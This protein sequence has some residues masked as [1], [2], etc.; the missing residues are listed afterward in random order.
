VTTAAATAAPG[1]RRAAAA[2]ALLSLAAAVV[3]LVLASLDRW[4]VLVGTVASLA[5]AVVAAWYVLSRR[6]TVR[7]LAA[8]LVAVALVV[9]LVALVGSQSVRVVLLGLALGAASVAAAGYALASPNAGGDSER[10]PAARHPV[11]LMNPRSGGGKVE[12]FGLVELCRQHGVEPYVLQPGDD[13]RSVAEEAV[14]G[15]ADLI[16]MAGGDGSLAIVATVASRHGIPFVVV[17]A[18]TRNHFALD[19]GIDRADVP[20]ALAAYEDGIDTPVDLAE[21]NGR[22][23]VNNA[24]M[25]VYAK[26][27]QSADYR[28]AKV[29]TAA[30]LLPDML[31]PGSAPL[32]LRYALP[33][34][35]P[36]V[37]GQLLLVSNNPYDLARLRGGGT[38]E[39]LDGGV[40]GVVSLRVSSATDAEKV[41]ALELTGQVQRFAG[42]NEWTAPEFEVSSAEPVEVGVDGE[43]LV[44]DPPLRF[45]SR[46]SAVTVRLP[47]AALQRAH[48][49]HAPRVTTGYTVAALWQLA[50]RR[51]QEA[52]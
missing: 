29:Q 37:P 16:G 50:T 32:D 1:A 24:S 51:S 11:L 28:D 31:G 17:P 14:A 15:G 27:V 4:L 21:V 35:E 13:L 19:L 22:V 46:P 45:A 6:G 44:L 30:T 20:A 43:A 48:A 41:A 2:L 47:R 39:R 10:A 52:R 40:L 36:A 49:A 34:G 25:G 8:V 23:F 12:R 42:W 38:R 18:G 7:V 26:V 33:S 3:V 5:V 9:F